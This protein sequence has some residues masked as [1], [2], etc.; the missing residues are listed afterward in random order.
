MRKAFA[1]LAVFLFVVGVSAEPI[2]AQVLEVVDG[3]T[4]RVRLES[5]PA[6]SGLSSG[7]VEYVRYI[8]VQLP[9]APEETELARSLNAILVSGRKVFLELDEKIHD[10]NGRV[11]AYVFLDETE[12]LMVNAILISTDIF[13]FGSVPGASRYDQV[14]SYLEQ[15]PTAA[16]GKLAC[17]A[18]YTWEEAR[19]R[20]GETACVE[21]PVASVGTSRSGDVFLNLGR[22]YPDPGRFTLFIP[23]RH[24]GK[25]EIVFGPRFWTTLEGRIVRAL[26]TI[27]EYQGIPEIELSDPANLVIL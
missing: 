26:G 4:I 15:I 21:G 8:G 19:N 17:P 7:A 22:P 12:K 2:V 5:A 20:L 25:F 1:I 6:G 23:A 11:L 3:A 24:V 14:F 27:E 9:S 18:L 16:K 13:G 10:E